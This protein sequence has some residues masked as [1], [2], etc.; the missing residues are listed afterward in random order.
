M[1]ILILSVKLPFPPRDGG[2]LASLNMAAGLAHSG[3][4]VTF[5]CFNT[6][7]HFFSEDKIPSS[8]LEKIRFICI[9]TDTSL[10][11]FMAAVNLVFSCKPYNAK[12]F[13]SPAFQKKLRDLLLSQEF[14]IVQLEGPYL[15]WYI[16]VIRKLSAAKISL[17]AHNVEFMIWKMKADNDPNF[18]RKTYLKIL[19]GRIRGFEQHAIRDI[20][21]LVP[22]T[23][24]DADILRNFNKDIPFI[25]IPPGLELK[26]YPPHGTFTKA[27]LFYIGS[28]EWIPNQEGLL[29]F[30]R[31]VW[32]RQNITAELHVAGRNAPQWLE[33]MLLNTPGM[34]YHGEV[35]DAIDFMSQYDVLIS[36]LSSGSGIRIKIME[37]MLMGKIVVAS[38]CAVEGLPV[39]EGENILIAGNESEFLTKIRSVLENPGTYFHIR[40]KARR[41]ISENF[42][43]LALSDKLTGFYCNYL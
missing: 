42:N 22:V 14:D 3:N 5:L 38:P 35:E 43:N 24:K 11:I 6:R 17:R 27:S 9:K 15:A 1:R 19:A 25:V 41:L 20:D 37:A 30:I 16:P 21:M 18:L 39:T 29:W 34:V 2:A 4:E 32:D 36:P 13:Y 7:K 28:L 12:R 33:K 26:K 10:S 8:I 31:K 23:E 40:E